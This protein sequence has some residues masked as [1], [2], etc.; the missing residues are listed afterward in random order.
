METGDTKMTFRDFMVQ[1]FNGRKLVVARKSE[2][3]IAR[4]YE[5]FLSQR[6]YR[7]L[8]MAAQAAGYSECFYGARQ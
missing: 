7:E 4:G 6:Q 8:D 5:V 3:L 1:R 2:Q